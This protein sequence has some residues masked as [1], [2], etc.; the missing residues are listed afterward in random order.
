MKKVLC[1]LIAVIFAFSLLSGCGQSSQSK[2]DG[3]NT[4]QPGSSDNSA[5]TQEVK[6]EP[7]KIVFATNEQP[8]LP[9]E[10]WKIPTE[11]FMKENPNVTIENIAQPSSN[12]TLWDYEK[13]L[14]ATGQFPDILVVNSVTDFASSGALLELS[15]DDLSF[16]SNPDVGAYKGKYYL[17][18]YKKMLNGVFY[19]KKIF[20]DQGLSEPKNFKDFIDLCEKLKAGNITPVSFG[21]KDGWMEGVVAGSILT[22]FLSPANPNW[23]ADLNA[24]KIKFNSPEFKSAMEKYVQLTKNYCGKD[25]MSVSYA[26]SLEA[27]FTGKAAMIPIG[28]W[29]LGEE[30]KAKP[31][32]EIGFFPMPGENDANTLATYE[33]E[34]IAISATTKNPE[35]CKAFAKFFLSDKEWYGQFLKTEML[36]ATT[37]D[38]V[39]YDMSKT[40]KDMEARIQGLKEVQS[41]DSTTGD[42]ALL[43]GLSSYLNKFAANLTA[44]AGIDK[45]LDLFDK[46]WERAKKALAK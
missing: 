5:G 4:A 32:F 12:V 28:S 21:A 40:R 38:S 7:V 44:G 36:F 16:V 46:E 43:P 11:K 19:N 18:P 23:T 1:L 10:F 30:E 39:Q 42:N 27:F 9:K 33:N 8:Q 22:A 26:Q 35:V 2:S 34:G 29:L 3:S 13:T 14:L 6:K 15:K 24:G 20:A 25:V 17:H 31:G 37:K 41:W 45:E